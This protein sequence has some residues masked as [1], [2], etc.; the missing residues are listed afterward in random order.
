MK[1]AMSSGHGKYI[2]GA[3]GDPVPPQCDEVDEVRRIVDRVAEYL[4]VGN[5]D[6]ET[7]HDDVSDTQSENLDRIVKWHNAQ[8][9][10]LDVSVHLNAYDGSAHGTE[11]LY[12]SGD[13]QD[14][15]APL[16]DAISIAGNFFNR[17]DKERDDLAFLNGTNETSV[18]IETFFCDNGGD[19]SKYNLQ[20]EGIC[21]AIAESLAGRAIGEQP[22]EHPP[23]Q[24]PEHPPVPPAGP[25][26]R[27]PENIPVTERP[28]LRQGDDGMH[29]TDLQRMLLSPTQFGIDNVDGDFGPYT[30]DEVREYQTSRGLIVDGIVG[31]ETWRSLYANAPPV[32]PPAPPPHAL[33]KRDQE[34][35]IS[36]ANNSAISNFYW[37]D[38]GVAPDGYTQGMA[39]AFAQSYLKLKA[40]HPAVLQMARAERDSN[41]DALHVYHDEY[42]DLDMYNDLDGIDT[43]R[44]LYALMLGHGMRESSGRHCEG[45]DQSADNVES[46][47][48]EAGLFQ[49]SYNASSFSEPYFDNLM[50]EY[51]DP[52]NEATCYFNIFAEDVECSGDD[53]S[54]YG[55]GRGAE[56]Q[57]LCKEC[58][59]FSVET[60]AL[61]L[62]NRCDH[63]GPIKRREVELE[64]DA[65]RMFQEVQDYIDSGVA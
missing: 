25:G 30:D 35:I 60:A 27:P 44:H 64:L 56:F 45:R 21:R 59:P 52:A 5:V 23:V 26:W 48:A 14:I 43:L 58:P 9:R 22:P 34:A 46:S 42:E 40:R 63:Y 8:T 18:L 1:I 32:P 15:A 62:R 38:R 11:V 10:E 29:V 4:R 31:E 12:T 36:I 53:W 50:D 49:T 37:E 16:S 13:G 7:F 19:C 6:V 17:G 39:L 47:T 28:T 3:S 33:S 24:P 2:R 61:T 20:F 57:K 41:Y 54:N 55:S 51:D 65:D